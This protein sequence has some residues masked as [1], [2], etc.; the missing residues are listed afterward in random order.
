[1][2]LKAA[3]TFSL[4]NIHGEKTPLF[5]S[6]S[7]SPTD[8]SLNLPVSSGKSGNLSFAVR[9]SKASTTT[10]VSGVVFEPFEEVKKE[11]DLVPSGPQISLA[12]HLYSPECEAAVNE[13]IK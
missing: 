6:I 8:F 13:Q 10:T 1:M 2:L 7:S 3:S 4:L 11:L 5:S 12:R 9:A